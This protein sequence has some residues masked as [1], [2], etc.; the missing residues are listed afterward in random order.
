M[1]EA[2]ADSDPSPFR[3]LHAAA[4]GIDLPPYKPRPWLFSGK[5][6]TI[7]VPLAK[8]R[9]LHKDYPSRRYVLPLDDNSGDA[10]D[11]Y[12]YWPSHRGPAEGDKPAFLLVHGLGGHAHSA[13]ITCSA[14][15]LLAAGHDVLMPNFRGAGTARDLARVLHHPGRSDDL[16]LILTALGKEAPQLTQRD[17]IA[18]G[19]SLGGHLLLK[20]LADFD[21]RGQP[22]G[23]GKHGFVRGAVTVSAPLSLDGTSRALSQPMNYPFNLYLLRKIRHEVLRPNAVLSDAERQAAKAARTVREFDETFSAP[24]LGEPSA[25]A[26]YAASSAIDELAE[27]HLPTLMVQSLDDPFIDN[28]DYD[29]PAI[30]A[31]PNLQTV[32][33]PDGGHVGFFAGTH[34][35]RWIDQTLLKLADER[36]WETAGEQP[37]AAS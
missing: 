4:F 10:T 34:G 23:E 6:Q 28:A 26:F 21:V 32:I 8:V 16:D 9:D 5:L 31:N 12:H 15:N 3:T 24:R 11:L 20:F 7:G 30:V 18:V 19:Y 13:Y 2:I 25:E 33:L 35:P 37:T 22:G 29:H 36:F 1:P 27:I 14:A 17:T